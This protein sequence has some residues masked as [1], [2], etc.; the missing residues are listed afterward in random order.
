MKTDKHYQYFIKTVDCTSYLLQAP[1]LILL[2]LIIF[3]FLLLRCTITMKDYLVLITSDHEDDETTPSSTGTS[4]SSSSIDELIDW[5]QEHI[6]L[7]SNSTTTLLVKTRD[8]ASQ[9]QS[10]VTLPR[11]KNEEGTGSPSWKLDIDILAP[12]DED[13]QKNDT[14]SSAKK[15]WDLLL[16][17]KILDLRSSSQSVVGVFF[18]PG[19]RGSLSPTALDN[20][21]RVC[22]YPHPN[23]PLALNRSTATLCV[24][25]LFHTRVAYVIFNPAAGQRPPEQDMASLKKILE[26]SMRLKI[27]YTERDRSIADQCAEIVTMLQQEKR[28]QEERQEQEKAA[29]YLAERSIVPDRESIIIAS[30][31]DGTVSAIAGA[32]LNSG[33]PVGIIPRGTANAFSVALGIPTDSV[34]EACHTILRGHVRAVDGALLS[35][36]LL[37]HSSL[38]DEDEVKNNDQTDV[39]DGTDQKDLHIPQTTRWI[40]HAGLGFEAG[41]VDNA[42]RQLKD[43]FGNLAYTIGA[44]QQVLKNEQFRCTFVVDGDES[45]EETVETNI[46]TIANVDAPSS[47]FAQGFGKVIPDDGF[48]EVTIGTATGLNEIRQLATLVANALVKDSLANDTLL[49]FRCKKIKVTCDPPQKL[50]VDGEVIRDMDTITFTCVP[51]GLLVFAP[52][53]E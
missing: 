6:A 26:P 12:E 32:T 31:G 35:A 18:F 8:I 20:I 29:R 21:V 3:L 22:Q 40:N 49:T 27:S 41:L 2:L 19:R 36:E 1:V 39:D 7:L 43:K 16:V 5:T 50:L 44:A 10:E 30:G 9:L 34:E 48:F 17:H 13:E 42:T 4:S 38:L 14:D 51:K 24:R 11:S 28:Q 25:S 45:K 53:T 52:P 15:L 46:I 37:W 23:I 47:V 33:I